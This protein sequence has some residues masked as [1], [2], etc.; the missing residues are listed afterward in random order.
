MARQNQIVIDLKAGSLD[1]RDV[2][3]THVAGREA[4]SE[5]YAFEVEFFPSA[6]DPLD[7]IALRGAEALLTLHRPDGSERHAHGILWAVELVEVAAG[8]PRY[9][10][11][12]VPQLERLRHVRRSRIFQS[13]SVPD[14][15]K[16]VLD[17]GKVKH[18]LSLSASYPEREYRV[19][20]RESDLEF[21]HRLLEEE[22]IFYFFE[23]RADEHVMVLVDAPSGCAKLAGD[24]AIPFRIAEVGGDSELDE[25]LFRLERTQRIRAGKAS[26]KDFDFERPELQVTGSSRAAGD[27][28][29]L[30]HYEYPG[31]FL[32]PSV[33]TKRSS[34]RLEELRFGTETFAGGGTCLR[35]VS[36]AT[37]EPSGHPDQSFDQKLL[38]VRVEH[39][40]R[41]QEGTG[42][43]AVVERGY[44]NR[45]LAIDAGASYRPLRRTRRPV[46]Y[47]ETATVTGPDGEEIHTDRHGRVKVH[48][49]WDRDGRKDDTASCWIRVAQGWAGAAWG[50][51]ILP[52]IG[53]EVL[54]RFLDGDPDRP[55]VVGA[56]YNGANPPPIGLPGDKTKSTLR[57]DSSPGSG[58]TNELRLEDRKDGEEIFLHAQ[59]DQNIVVL[60]DKAQRVGHDEAL[61]VAKD[62]TIAV[63]ADQHLRVA[64][65]DASRIDG[66]LTLTV[67]G[68]RRTA[69]ALSHLEEVSAQQSSVVGGNR[70]VIVGGAATDTVGAAAALNVGGGFAVTVAAAMNKAVGGIFSG[71]VGGARLEAVGATREEQVEKASIA[72]VGGDFQS[73]VR[74]HVSL[75][76][77]AD[78]KH[79]V[80]GKQGV[81]VKDPVDWLAKQLKLEADSVSIVVGGKVAL[82]M[83]KSGNVTFGVS[84][85][86]V[87]GSQLTLKGS[88]VTKVASDQAAQKAAEVKQLEELRS[89]RAKVEFSLLDQDGN[90]VANEPFVVELPDGTVKKGATDASGKAAV[91]GSKAGECKISF[92]RLDPGSVKIG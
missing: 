34:V 48:F 7:L 44:R 3:V 72:R 27:E 85:L 82:S 83:K 38:L 33:G 22:G 23:H 79:D 39:E 81:E 5:P 54:V 28:L 92:P 63:K 31:G 80:G 57:T 67:T 86:T 1:A 21:V 77:G 75:T 64:A 70:N 51:S 26:L 73:D 2:A 35:F 74:G 30:E 56:I 68:S 25:H 43:T 36:G 12:L 87:D 91:G 62:R 49:H 29:G 69:V 24:S 8:G 46:A 19:Q 47:A 65:M 76:T 37:F 4:L 18:R 78:E 41:Q 60:N 42:D 71:Q 88:Q 61:E 89:S 84:S 50:A 17:A 40:A 16:K 90:P 14:L 9:R 58:G 15:V 59:K 55:L 13:I 11:R 52:R 20:Y 10:A 45:F 66:S 32:D 53:Q 6:R